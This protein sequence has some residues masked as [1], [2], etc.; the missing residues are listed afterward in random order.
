MTQDAQ[1]ALRRTMETYSR[2]TRFC[3]ICN[4]VTRIIDPLASRCTKF[5]FKPLDNADTTSRLQYIAE[6]E[7]VHCEPGVIDAL[8]T[9]SGGDMRRAI[10][11]LQ[12]AARLVGHSTLKSKEGGG[13]KSKEGDGDDEVSMQTGVTVEDVQEIAGVVPDSVLDRL[14]NMCKTAKK[15][16][17]LRETVDQIVAEGYSAGQIILQLHD[18]IIEDESVETKA[19]NSI[20]SDIAEA[21]TMLNDGAG[22]FFITKYYI[23]IY[24]CVCLSMANERRTIATVIVDCWYQQYVDII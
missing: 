23:Y 18:V 5:R 14:W 24:T 8:V 7:G 6:Q 20:L 11:Y 2:I 3:L 1:S 21:D 10:T 19:R 16:E 12:S 13:I 15:Y 22:R 4:Y 9:T 17:V